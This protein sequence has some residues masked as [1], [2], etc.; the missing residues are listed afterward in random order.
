MSTL[1]ANLFRAA[2]AEKR[3]SHQLSVRNVGDTPILWV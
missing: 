1:S 2:Y 3:L